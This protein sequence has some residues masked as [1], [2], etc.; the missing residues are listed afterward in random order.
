MILEVKKSQMKKGEFFLGYVNN[1]KQADFFDWRT[2]QTA[3]YEYGK[4]IPIFVNKVEMLTRGWVFIDNFALDSE[5]LESM[6]GDSFNKYDVFDPE[7]STL[8]TFQQTKQ[9]YNL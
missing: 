5:E 3:G 6:N 1:Q 4:G 7:T 2:V 9:K 8:R